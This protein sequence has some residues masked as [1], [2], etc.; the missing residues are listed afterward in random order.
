MFNLLDE[1]LVRQI[2][3]LAQLARFIT[4]SYSTIHREWYHLCQLKAMLSPPTKRE[5][6]TTKEATHA[7]SAALRCFQLLGLDSLISRYFHGH[8][9]TTIKPTRGKP[10]FSIALYQKRLSILNT[11][12]D[13]YDRKRASVF[14]S[15]IS[16]WWEKKN[17]GT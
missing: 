7:T 8:T 6:T 16:G 3:P 14:M 1:Y 11:N 15:T 4:I 13:P 5:T 10:G 2:R 12:R 9:S 17:I